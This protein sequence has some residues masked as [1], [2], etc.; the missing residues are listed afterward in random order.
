MLKYITLFFSVTF[1]LTACSSD[2]PPANVINADRMTRLLTQLHI[3]DGGL[4][5][6]PQS[7]DSLYKY[8]TERYLVLFK[9][10]HTDSA[11]FKRSLKYYATQP[12]K[13]MKIYDKVLDNIRQK[14]DSVNKSLQRN[15][16]PRK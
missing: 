14:Q 6:L 3:V 16:I 11:Q 13:I 5:N 7:P 9:Q 15:V 2:K 12:D 8:G 1:F 10:F 4:F